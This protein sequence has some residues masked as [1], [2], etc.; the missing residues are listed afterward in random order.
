MLGELFDQFRFAASIALG[1]DF[2]VRS[3]DRLVDAVGATHP[4]CSK[5]Q[6]A[7][8]SRTQSRARRDFLVDLTGLEPV[9]LSDA[10][11]ALSQLSYRPQR[12]TGNWTI[13]GRVRV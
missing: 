10:N 8:L 7:G 13:I 2:D 6:V 3:L 12:A 5:L 4:F 9:N 1:L 11:R